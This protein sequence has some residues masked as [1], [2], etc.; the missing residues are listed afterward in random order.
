MDQVDSPVSLLLDALPTHKFMEEDRTLMNLF[1]QSGFDESWMDLDY[2]FLNKFLLVGSPYKDANEFIQ[3]VLL[4]RFIENVDYK[5]TNEHMNECLYQVTGFCLKQLCVMSSATT[6]RFFIRSDQL[7]QKLTLTRVMERNKLKMSTTRLSRQLKRLEEKVDGLT[8]G[9]APEELLDVY[10]VG[11]AHYV[12]TRHAKQKSDTLLIKGLSILSK[13][14]C[15]DSE[16]MKHIID[17]MRTL[18]NVQ[19]NNIYLKGK[20]SEQLLINTL[21]VYS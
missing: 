20:Q 15:L 6:A 12:F 21:T 11:K 4:T 3:N 18:F 7:A 17:N 10:R 19:G 5:L 16:H 14:I 9:G 2:T 8:K 1:W 13:P